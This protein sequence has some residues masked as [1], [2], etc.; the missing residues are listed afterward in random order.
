MPKDW[1]VN[2]ARLTK[3]ADLPA[4]TDVLEVILLFEAQYGT[5]IVPSNYRTGQRVDFAK[6]VSA[7]LRQLGLLSRTNIPTDYFLLMMTNH[8]FIKPVEGNWDSKIEV[9]LKDLAVRTLSGAPDEFAAVVQHRSKRPLT[10]AEGYMNSCSRYGYWLSQQEV[11]RSITH[12]HSALP[13]IVTN[14]LAEGGNTVFVPPGYR[15][16]ATVNLRTL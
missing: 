4:L 14:T 13:T 7:L 9:L 5:G 10:W 3:L 11:A 6:D 15:K 2:K 8:Y 12:H 1:I 16:Q